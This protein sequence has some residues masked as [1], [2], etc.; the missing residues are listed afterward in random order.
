MKRNRSNPIEAVEWVKSNGPVDV[1][2]FLTFRY[3]YG[4]P[5]QRQSDKARRVLSS[6]VEAGLLDQKIS[7]AYIVP[8][9]EDMKASAKRKGVETEVKLVEWLRVNGARYA[10]RRHLSGANDKGD[11]GAIPGV[12]LDAKSGVKMQPLKWLREIVKEVR[13]SGADTGAVIV[14]P[15]GKPDPDDWVVMMTMEM[16]RDLMIEAGYFKRDD[17]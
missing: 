8:E 10:E 15:K 5:T 6:M 4:P 16:Y 17:S 3:G 11:I 9:M 7:G 2:D 1:V 12:C 13:N 14:R